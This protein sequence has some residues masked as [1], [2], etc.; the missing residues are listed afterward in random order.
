MDYNGKL[1]K[2]ISEDLIHKINNKEI[3]INDADLQHIINA[4]DAEIREMDD[5]FGELVSL[6][7]E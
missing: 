7:K 2:H 5:S 1:P 4:Y 6:L 3:E